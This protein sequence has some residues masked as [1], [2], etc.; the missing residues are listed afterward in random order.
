MRRL[1]AM[2]P[3]KWCFEER[4]LRQPIVLKLIVLILC[5]FL[6]VQ[7]SA[8]TAEIEKV[9]EA[10][11]VFESFFSIPEETIPASL[12]RQAEAIAIIPGTIKIGFMLAARH[13][14][15]IMI[16]K[17]EQGRWGL[18]FFVNILG[19]SM[20]WQMGLQATDVILVFKKRKGMTAIK[21]GKVTLG[22][23]LSVAAGPFGRQVTAA[24]DLQFDSEV[25]SYSRNKGVFIGIALEGAVL[26]ADRS[27]TE[28]LYGVVAEDVPASGKKPPQAVLTFLEKFQQGLNSVPPPEQ[29]QTGVK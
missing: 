8:H 2:L 6:P 4:N 26:Q 24:T 12:L 10:T 28:S 25:Y 15:G 21:N 17:D 20:G 23:D 18:P 14:R 27:G 1:G 9:R 16:G 5:W 11:Q 3:L 19:G 13:G 22:A 7:V 29:A